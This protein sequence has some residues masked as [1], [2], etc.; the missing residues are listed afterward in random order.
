MQ[1]VLIDNATT[2]EV[3]DHFPIG[4]CGLSPSR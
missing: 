2:L 3:R 4:A 1:T